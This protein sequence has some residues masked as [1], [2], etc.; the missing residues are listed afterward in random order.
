M[1]IFVDSN[2][3]LE[4]LL[5]RE[6]ADVVNEILLWADEEDCILTISAGAAY[7]LTYTLDKYLRKENQVSNPKRINL[8]REIMGRIYT[9]YDVRSLSSGD[10]YKA[11]ADIRFNDLEDGY[12]WHVAKTA[13]CDVVLTLNIKDFQGVRGKEGLQVF[14]PIEFAERFIRVDNVSSV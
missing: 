1:N 10:F 13:N 2:I 9:R 7:T 5:D 14:S 12:Q 3:I 11:S 6:N 8:V 4:Y